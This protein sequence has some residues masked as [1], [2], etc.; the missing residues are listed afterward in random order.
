MG[1]F[2][3]LQTI[4]K[5]I[6]RKLYQLKIWKTEPMDNLCLWFSECQW[7]INVSHYEKIEKWPPFHKY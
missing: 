7:N 1:N 2:L 4:I 6:Q 3:D 5:D